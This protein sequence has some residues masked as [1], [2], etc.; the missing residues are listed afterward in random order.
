MTPKQLNE[1]TGIS[2]RTI[3]RDLKLGKLAATT[4]YKYRITTTDAFTWSLKKWMENEDKTK[5]KRTVMFSIDEIARR[6]NTLKAFSEIP[7]E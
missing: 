6:F 5:T 2:L 1:C 4:R 3:Y 7:E